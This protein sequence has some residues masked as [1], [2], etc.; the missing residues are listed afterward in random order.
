MSPLAIDWSSNSMLMSSSLL[1]VAVVLVLVLVLVVVGFSFNR[2][3]VKNC[4][5]AYSVGAF[6]D[7]V[8]QEPPSQKLL[9]RSCF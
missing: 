4:V 9:A 5:L 7:S 6:L 3:L 2:S 8:R 1:L